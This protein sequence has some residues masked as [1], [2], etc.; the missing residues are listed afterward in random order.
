MTT[1]P[2]DA[3]GAVVRR[4][5][6]T[7]EGAR[8]DHDGWPGQSYTP[9]MLRAGLFVCVGVLFCA[10]SLQSFADPEFQDPVSA[11]DWFAVVSFSAALF[12]LALALPMLAQLIDGGRV[13]FR[14]SLVPAAGAAFAGLSNLLEDALQMGFAFW[15][16][17]VGTVLTI[18]GLIAFTLVVAVV[19]RGRRRPL[20]T[21]SAA[22]LI[23]VLLFEEGGGVVIAAA[24]LAA[25]AISLRL[26]ARTDAR[27]A[28]TSP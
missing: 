16:F 24:W 17:I 15:F 2:P 12:A 8:S 22:T 4:C 6:L 11:S 25:A 1:V 3:S 5:L 18:L 21:V 23:G 9:R 10:R 26:P 28:P 19:S 20:A 14:V 13:V 7:R 27:A